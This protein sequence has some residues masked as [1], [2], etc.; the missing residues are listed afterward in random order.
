[1]YPLER[2][3]SAK[4]RPLSIK[5]THVGYSFYSFHYHNY[6]HT[7]NV[8]IFQSPVQTDIARMWFLNPNF[9]SKELETGKKL[10]NDT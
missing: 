5:P 10:T 8:E 1:M 2:F 9:M 4:E 7:V 6:N 3:D